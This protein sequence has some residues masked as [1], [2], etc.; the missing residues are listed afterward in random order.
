MHKPKAKAETLTYVAECKPKADLSAIC[1]N[2]KPPRPLKELYASI[3]TD[4]RLAITQ[5]HGL[6]VT[7][8]VLL[9]AR[10]IPK[11][12]SGKVTR[13]G[14]QKGVQSGTLL[15][16]TIYRWDAEGGTDAS[17]ASTSASASASTGGADSGGGGEDEDAALL[18]SERPEYAQAYAS[19][20]GGG[21]ARDRDLPFSTAA[22]LHALPEAA[23][24]A[25]L[26]DL[27]V[28]VTEGSPSP[29]E[30]PVDPSATLLQLGL[31]SMT[32]AQFKGALDASY[33]TAHEKQQQQQQQEGKVGGG[34]AEEVRQADNSSGS[35]SGSGD[36]EA[37]EVELVSL[38][39]TGSAGASSSSSSQ[40][41]AASEAETETDA[42]AEAEA[43]IPDD[44]LFTTLASLESLAHAV[45]RGGLSLQQKNAFERALAGI[46]DE[47][48][49]GMVVEIQ[50]QPVCP[51]F[52][53]CFD[54]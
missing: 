8:I 31:D 24:L 50:R 38:T 40:A 11:T 10:S 2:T 7:T 41:D 48:E 46:Q 26:T 47:D 28:D 36:K 33:F 22:E 35:G 25:L 49:D 21:S 20:S 42:E 12:T 27:L 51:W 18:P 13:K 14:V 19:G 53:V 54:Y 4:I 29:Q 45:R 37:K 1:K 15:K 17:A 23:I 5:D 34:G 43:G 44:F 52:V 9:D 30:R 39:G 16:S 32:V 6:A 3:C